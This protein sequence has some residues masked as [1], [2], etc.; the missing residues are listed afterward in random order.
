M[1]NDDSVE[2]IQPLKWPSLS[3]IKDHLVASRKIFR[4]LS[5]QAAM[6]VHLSK[7][8]FNPVNHEDHVSI[9]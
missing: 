4:L 6:L 7:R 1:L 8:I 5:S 2:N 9:I 3:K